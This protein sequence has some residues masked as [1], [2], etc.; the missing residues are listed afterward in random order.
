[1][2]GDD[3]LRIDDILELNVIET[4]VFLAHKRDKDKMMA[5]LRSNPK[6]NVTQL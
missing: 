4:H 2:A 3:I 6:G 1:L 5:E